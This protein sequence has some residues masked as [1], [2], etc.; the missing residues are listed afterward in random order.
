[1]AFWLCFVPLLAPLLLWLYPPRYSHRRDALAVVGLYL[2]ATLAA[3]LIVRHL[4]RRSP[5]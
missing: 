2:V 1:M 3:W 5:G 4:R